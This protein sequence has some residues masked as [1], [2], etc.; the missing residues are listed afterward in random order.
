MTKLL[1]EMSDIIRPI[2]VVAFDP[3]SETVIAVNDSHWHLSA[4]NGSPPA[5]SSGATRQPFTHTTAPQPSVTYRTVAAFVQQNERS[6]FAHAQR[7]E[8]SE[9]SGRS[10][11]SNRRYSSPTASKTPEVPPG[12]PQEYVPK[13]IG[14]LDLEDETGLHQQTKVMFHVKIRTFGSCGIATTTSSIYQPELNLP[15][16]AGSLTEPFL[17]ATHFILTIGLD[18]NHIKDS[19]SQLSCQRPPMHHWLSKVSAARQQTKGI[20]AR[21]GMNPIILPSYM[22]TTTCTKNY[23]PLQEVVDF[24]QVK[25]NERSDTKEHFWHYVFQNNVE[26]PVHFPDEYVSGVQY[27]RSHPVDTIRLFFDTVLVVNNKKRRGKQDFKF[28]GAKQVIMKY[29]LSFRRYGKVLEFNGTGWTTRL[30]HKIE[31]LPM[32]AVWGEEETDGGQVR[33]KVGMEM[34]KKVRT[35]EATAN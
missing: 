33:A 21:F 17:R 26:S 13:F 7:P 11:Q 5:F 15:T 4:P 20:T 19:S 24:T 14:I 25:I 30:H 32:V 8:D 16:T 29:R 23:T 22:S 9:G 18:D 31:A 35:I 3:S 27:N 34:E 2:P 1:N 6:R 10:R 28:C 12:T